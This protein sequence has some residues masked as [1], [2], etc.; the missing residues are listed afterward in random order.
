MK[1]ARFL[2]AV[3][4]FGALTL[5][6]GFAA[7]PSSQPPERDPHKHRA[8]TVRPAGPAHGNKDQG[9]RA[10]I[11]ELHQPGL[12][13]AATAANGGLMLNKMRNSHEQPARLP[14]GGRTTVPLPGVVHA[15]S[16]TKAAAGGRAAAASVK[17]P[18]LT[19]NGADFIKHKTY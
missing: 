15:R 14:T 1:T 18:G 4:G 6:V 7:E 10:P 3:V 8:T 5:G 16:A 2:F 9:K 19:L 13:K 17:H 11:T 12:N